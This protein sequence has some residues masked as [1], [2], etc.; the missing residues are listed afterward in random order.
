MPRTTA[1]YRGPAQIGLK[2]RCS[3]THS[4]AGTKVTPIISVN[5][6]TKFTSPGVATEEAGELQIKHW[7]NGGRPRNAR[8]ASW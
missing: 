1:P 2:A 8:G 5:R 4:L 3:G 7:C 6:P